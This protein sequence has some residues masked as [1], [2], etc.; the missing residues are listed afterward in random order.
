[1]LVNLT[2]HP[3]NLIS[4]EGGEYVI[5]PSGSVARVQEVVL[6]TVSCK[7]PNGEHVAGRKV[8]TGEVTG[9]PEEDGEHVYIVSRPVALAV[10]G[11]NDVMVPD[12]FVRDEGGRILGCRA[13]TK[14]TA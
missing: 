5:E 8:S 7:L 10:L 1:M 6:K 14:F 3:I 4:K 2:P 11:R 9:L 12:D 13:V